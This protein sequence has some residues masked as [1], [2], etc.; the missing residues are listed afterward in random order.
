MTLCVCVCGNHQTSGT[1]GKC[2]FTG[3]RLTVN[4]IFHHIMRHSHIRVSQVFPWNP[5]I[6]LQVGCFLFSNEDSYCCFNL[7]NILPDRQSICL[8]WI[9]VTNRPLYSLITYFCLGHMVEGSLT[10]WCQLKGYRLHSYCETVDKSKNTLHNYI[11]PEIQPLKY[12]SICFTLSMIQD[13]VWKYELL[14]S[15]IPLY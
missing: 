3:R 10:L 6:L 13:H 14:C 2:I 9:M 15:T 12:Q 5:R 7:L 8:I 11:S 4:M 1:S